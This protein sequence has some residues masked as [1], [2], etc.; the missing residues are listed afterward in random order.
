MAVWLFRHYL[1]DYEYIFFPDKAVQL[2]LIKTLL[3]MSL[4]VVLFWG[5]DWLLALWLSPGWWRS[6]LAYL[7]PSM[8]FDGLSTALSWSFDR[9]IGL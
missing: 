6:A 9:I 3:M 8:L 7:I 2:A 1:M 5:T 4:L